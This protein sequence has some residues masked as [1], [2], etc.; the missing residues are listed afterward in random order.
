MAADEERGTYYSLKVEHLHDQAEWLVGATASLVEVFRG[1][2]H[3]G[4]L[5]V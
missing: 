3:Q 5:A 4:L 1:T 2:T